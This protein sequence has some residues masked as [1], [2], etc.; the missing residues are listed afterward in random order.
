MLILGI[1]I[2]VAIT[3]TLG[4]CASASDAEDRIERRNEEDRARREERK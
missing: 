3:I 4:L 1:I 2:G